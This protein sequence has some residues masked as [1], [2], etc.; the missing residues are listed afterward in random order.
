VPIDPIAAA[1]AAFSRGL[2]RHG[3]AV[4]NAA[5]QQ[6][7]ELREA[8]FLKARFL[9]SIGFNRAAAEMLDGALAGQTGTPDRV[10]LLEEQAFLWAE[11]QRGAEALRSV[12]AAA[13][14][15]S[16][17]V[18]SHYLRGRALALLGRLQEAREGMKLVLALDPQNADAQRALS[19][20]EDALRSA[21]HKAW[22]QFWK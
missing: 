19:M 3:M 9:N 8:W 1:Q 7:A 11:C 16:D 4:L 14:L 17:S 2:F 15:G 21:P 12:E 5:L 10:W 22:R 18:R 20:I 6:G 13:A